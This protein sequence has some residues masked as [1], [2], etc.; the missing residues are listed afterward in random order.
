MKPPASTA[1]E[2]GPTGGASSGDVTAVLLM[3]NSWGSGFDD[4]ATLYDGEP[5]LPE[6]HNRH[7]DIDCYARFRSGRSGARDH[8]RAATVLS[9]MASMT[10]CLSRPSARSSP[11]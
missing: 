2:N 9:T 10:S 11:C 5:T 4:L 1:W 8:P 7:D 6:L 3:D